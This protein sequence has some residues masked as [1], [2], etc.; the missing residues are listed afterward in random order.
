MCIGLHS[1]R[2][3]GTV[4]LDMYDEVKFQSIQYQSADQVP[5]SFADDY[6]RR[7]RTIYAGAVHRL[8]KRI[9]HWSHAE[10]NGLHVST[11]ITRDIQ[12]HRYQLSSCT[13]NEIQ[14]V[15]KLDLVRDILGHN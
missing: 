2:V 3:C 8:S 13:H 12:N 7:V 5:E 15:I 1:L 6:F 11:A 10:S 14:V 9:N 4:L